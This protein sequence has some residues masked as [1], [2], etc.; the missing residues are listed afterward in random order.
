MPM[1]ALFVSAMMKFHVKGRLRPK[2]TVM[3][4]DPYVLIVELLAAYSGGCSL[5]PFKRSDLVEGTTDTSA[6]V[7]IKNSLPDFISGT[8]SRL[9]L[10]E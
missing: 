4:V 8:K 1:I 7:S 3:R 2:S 6:P 5:I 10:N 9:E